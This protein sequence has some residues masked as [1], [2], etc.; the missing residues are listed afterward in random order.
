MA[1]TSIFGDIARLRFGADPIFGEGQFA[2]VSRCPVQPF[3]RLFQFMHEANAQLRKPC[4]HAFCK[5]AHQLVR[6]DEAQ[7][8]ASPTVFRKKPHWFRDLDRD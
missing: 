7:P 6:L 1:S 2:I 5:D 8:S 4:G 3:A